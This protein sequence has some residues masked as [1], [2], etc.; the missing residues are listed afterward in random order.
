VRDRMA[1]TSELV[2]INSAGTD[3][4]NNQ[5]DSPAI[6]ADGSKIAFQSFASDLVSGVTDNNASN[7]VFLRNRTAGTTT[8]ISR[9]ST[10]TAS[11]NN[12]SDRPQ[13]SANGEA[14]V[15]FSLATDLQAGIAD[16]N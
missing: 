12:T 15:F 9:T 16:P 8:L 14:V 1:G 11:G 6:S 2:S 5:S 7:D 13:L 3:T 4:G 10:G